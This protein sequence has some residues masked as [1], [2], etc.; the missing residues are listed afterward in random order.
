M[1]HILVLIAEVL[2]AIVLFDVLVVLGLM[3]MLK[4]RHNEIVEAP[5]LPLQDSWTR[6]PMR[7]AHRHRLPVQDGWSRDE[8]IAW[9]TSG[10]N[11]PE[12][13]F[14]LQQM[15]VA[16][17][18]DETCPI[19]AGRLDHT[20]FTPHRL[21]TEDAPGAP[22]FERGLQHA[23]INLRANAATQTRMAA[24]NDGTLSDA[25]MSDAQL[26]GAKL[27]EMQDGQS[28]KLVGVDGRLA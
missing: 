21:V 11:F 12:R 18:P 28:I 6:G 14:S 16:F 3:M 2:A 4:L 8:T 13:L 25:D 7:L 9:A 20:G 15:T 24:N 1:N 27:C 17:S 26:L 10:R 22:I 19:C 23:V 5:Y